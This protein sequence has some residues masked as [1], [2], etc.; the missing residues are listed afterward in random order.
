[1]VW[2]EWIDLEKN[3]ARGVNE[4]C[5]LDSFG[6]VSYLEENVVFCTQLFR[7]HLNSRGKLKVSCYF[8][9]NISYKIRNFYLI[10]Q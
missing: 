10:L 4:V 3:E 9:G 7:F 2:V 1:M 6:N 5:I 8:L